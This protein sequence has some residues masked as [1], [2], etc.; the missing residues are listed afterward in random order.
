[1]TFN[2]PVD[3]ANRACQHM[4]V[5]RI[6]SLA[7]QSAPANELRFCYD[8]LRRAELQRNLWKFAT[9]RAI[10]RPL[11]T[12]TQIYTPPTFAS[13]TT[14]A[15]GQIVSYT[16]PDGAAHLYQS[17][18]GS[19]TG[20]LPID[21]NYLV[22]SAWWTLYFGNLTVSQWNGNSA[23]TP[24]TMGSLGYSAGELV[25]MPN[26]NAYLAMV[27]NNAAN[28]EVVDTWANDVL[29]QVGQVVSYNG[30]VYQATAVNIN[31]EPDIN[32]ASTGAWSS[33]TTY[34]A[35]D[36]A[37]ASDGH[38]YKSA[39]G[40]N[41]N[42]QP[43]YGANPTWWTDTGVFVGG[44][45]G[46]ITSSEVSNQWLKLTGTMA[47]FAVAYPLSSGPAT[48][49]TTKNAYMLPYGWL[50]EAPRDPKWGAAYL[51]APTGPFPDDFVYEG[52]FI[53]TQSVQ[54]LMI[55]YVADF[56]NV[57]QMDDM[58]CEGLAARAADACVDRLTDKPRLKQTIMADY[59]MF[60]SDARQKNAIEVG[61]VEPEQDPL[62]ACRL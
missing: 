10:L 34:N 30:T 56:T 53:V 48:Q 21:T 7:D 2:A 22:N 55:R 60:M 37:N 58:F 51:G 23:F 14:Y 15:Y 20:H 42:H 40:S 25:Y 61:Y 47:P 46:T 16:G 39:A 44:W 59:Q 36:Y 28:P 9:F 41:T 54:P 19:N 18:A 32:V 13:G 57:A 29:Y 1:M 26:Q 62:I 6:A 17:Q 50:K 33:G 45:T 52:Q 11:D 8:K 24:G 5:P 3:I 12:T 38:V 27:S 31:A 49:L 4:G 43:A 35:G